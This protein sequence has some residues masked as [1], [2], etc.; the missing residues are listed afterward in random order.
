MEHEFKLFGRKISIW[1]E[2]DRRTAKGSKLD[3]S[4]RGIRVSRLTT[5]DD[6]YDARVVSWHTN[7]FWLAIQAQPKGA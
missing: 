7:W 4:V 1:G 6:G 2:W 5:Q 3:S